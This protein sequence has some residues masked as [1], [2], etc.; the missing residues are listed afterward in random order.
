MSIFTGHCANQLQRELLCLALDAWRLSTA[1]LY[2]IQRLDRQRTATAST[3]YRGNNRRTCGCS[4]CDKYAAAVTAGV[5]SV[6]SMAEQ[7]LHGG[8]CTH[9]HTHM[10]AAST[11]RQRLPQALP[12]IEHLAQKCLN[13]LSNCGGS[14]TTSSADTSHSC[15]PSVSTWPESAAKNDLDLTRG[16][17]CTAQSRWRH[18]LECLGGRS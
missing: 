7:H 15:S 4:C 18:G 2:T 3:R 13:T 12:C 9:T 14:P 8:A 11:Q 10:S 5:S 16:G 17:S 1:P 6:L